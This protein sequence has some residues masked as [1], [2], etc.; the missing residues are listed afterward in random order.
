MNALSYAI[1][2]LRFRIPIAV[3]KIAF[4]ENNSSWRQ[5][6]VSLDDLIMQ[7]VIRARILVDAD[8]VGGQ[9]VTIPLDRLPYKMLDTYIALFEV[10]VERTNGRTIMSILSVGYLPY[11]YAQSGGV[12]TI[13]TANPNQTT[14]VL[15]A[16]LR[17]GNAMSA[18]PAVSTA[19]AEL[20]GHNVVVIRDNNR[21]AAPYLLRCV[22]G[23]EENLN[24]I[25]LRSYNQFARLVELGVKSYIYNKL[26]ID[27]DNAYLTGGQELG[28]VKNYVEGLADSEE[29]YR[30]FLEEEW[31]KVAWIQDHVA[32]QRLIRMQINPAL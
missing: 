21:P 14:N 10:P 7:H 20:V 2:Q 4:R 23:N 28:S 26:L 17:V 9:E 30:T 22:V 19:S 8:I 29:M 31:A 25:S 12:S 6:P 27:I 11:T 3:L 13:S 32:H 5:A 15:L 24:N 1:N 16:G 18:I